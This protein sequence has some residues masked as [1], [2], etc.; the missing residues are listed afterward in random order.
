M[1]DVLKQK[2]TVEMTV[3]EAL[4][5]YKV[6][7]HSNGEGSNPYYKLDDVLSKIG[8]VEAVAELSGLDTINYHGLQNEVERAFL[9]G[10]KYEAQKQI[11][12]LEED[13]K[14]LQSQIQELRATF[15]EG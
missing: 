13:V 6:M 14:K 5:V 12:K 15:G 4:C 7:Y 2:I 9:C 3:R 8:D 11:D 10:N 1:S